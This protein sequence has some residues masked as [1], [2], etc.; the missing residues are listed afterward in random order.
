MLYDDHSGDTENL[1]ANAN[2]KDAFG[3]LF[4]WQTSSETL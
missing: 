3:K 4:P 2:E 1:Q